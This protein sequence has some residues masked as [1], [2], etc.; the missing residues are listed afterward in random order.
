MSKINDIKWVKECKRF[1]RNKKGKFCY[2]AWLKG[3]GNFQ[4][5]LTFQFCRIQFRYALFGFEIPFINKKIELILPF[6]TSIFVKQNVY[7]Y[8]VEKSTVWY[9]PFLHLSF[10]EMKI[11]YSSPDTD[12]LISFSV[13]G[14]DK[15]P[16]DNPADL[17]NRIIEFTTA[18]ANNQR[19]MGYSG[20]IYPS[21][22]KSFKVLKELYTPEEKKS[23]MKTLISE[24][25]WF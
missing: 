14:F 23:L 3:T 22:D 24:K 20:E 2:H 18:F 12:K 8:N 5:H 25:R 9:I 1:G 6:G 7:W 11:H 15:N 17:D 21:Q 19:L 10:I 16:K 13:S 4:Y